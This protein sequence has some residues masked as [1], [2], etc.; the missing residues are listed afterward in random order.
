MIVGSYAMSVSPEAFLFAMIVGRQVPL[1]ASPR[2]TVCKPLQLPDTHQRY[3][4]F[5]HEGACIGCAPDLT[6]GAALAS[7]EDT[8]DDDGLVLSAYTYCISA[9]DPYC[10]T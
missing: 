8:S 4:A 7:R 6:C 10:I 5:L 3:F 9:F 1:F 2:R